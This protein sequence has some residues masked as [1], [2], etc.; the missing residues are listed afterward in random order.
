MFHT[1]A[2]QPQRKR[3]TVQNRIRLKG[4][5]RGQLNTTEQQ[6][7][8]LE[9]KAAS[10]GSEL[11]LRHSSFGIPL[12]AKHKVVNELINGGKYRPKM[13]LTIAYMLHVRVWVYTLQQQYRFHSCKQRGLIATSR[14]FPS[15]I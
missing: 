5:I 4:L 8:L 10:T 3:D 11:Q 9:K 7:Q 6:L 14:P 2:D 13:T 12:P 15:L 1:A